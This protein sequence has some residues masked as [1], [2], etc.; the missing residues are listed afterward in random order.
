MCIGGI[1]KSTPIFAWTIVTQTYAAVVDRVVS[2][3]MEK[4]ANTKSVFVETTTGALQCLDIY[5][6][7]YQ[8]EAYYYE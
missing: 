5:S 6:N 8:K 3:P 1:E 2:W 4:G 7:G